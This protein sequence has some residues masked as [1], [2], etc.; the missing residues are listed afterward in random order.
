[1]IMSDSTTAIPVKRILLDA[2]QYTPSAAVFYLVPNDETVTDWRV[3]YNLGIFSQDEQLRQGLK[4]IVTVGSNVVLLIRTMQACESFPE[5]F[6]LS[7]TRKGASSIPTR[8]WS[9]AS[10]PQSLPRSSSPRKR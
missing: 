8:Q 7:L 5:R 10:S 6:V 9:S 3:A 4:R 2:I 1:M